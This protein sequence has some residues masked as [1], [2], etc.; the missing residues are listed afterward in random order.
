MND[1]TKAG[2]L[3]ELGQLADKQAQALDHGFVSRLL[4]GE[5]PSSPAR[6]D[7]DHWCAVF[8][9]LIRFTEDLLKRVR[10]E[11]GEAP[12]PPVVEQE[13]E[14]L[15]LELQ[16][17]RAHRHYWSQRGGDPSRRAS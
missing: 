17:L 14:I 15:E 3:D 10:S 2:S 8:D 16:R 5:E 11:P 1:P 6:E 9:E 7:A 12:A 13:R 4:P